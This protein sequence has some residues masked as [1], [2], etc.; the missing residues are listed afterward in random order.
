M[1]ETQASDRREETRYPSSGD[2]VVRLLDPIRGAGASVGTDRW[3]SL[4]AC[5]FSLRGLCLST[6]HPLQP[7]DLLRMDVRLPGGEH[8]I[9]ALGEVRWSAGGRSGVKILS[10]TESGRNL[11]RKWCLAVKAS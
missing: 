8:Q 6:P 10:T 5:N 7:G 1:Q 4:P 11:M 2:G 3:T 9:P